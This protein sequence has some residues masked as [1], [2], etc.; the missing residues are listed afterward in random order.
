MLLR[1]Y[2]RYLVASD[3]CLLQQLLLEFII[4]HFEIWNEPIDYVLQGYV[5]DN[6]FEGFATKV[7]LTGRAFGSLLVLSEESV[8]TPLAISTHALVYCMSVTIDTFAEEASQ[9]LEH[10]CF[11]GAALRQ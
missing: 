2:N 3:L 8:N 5:P 1:F 9:I 11:G 7:Y 10:V 6:A 4:T